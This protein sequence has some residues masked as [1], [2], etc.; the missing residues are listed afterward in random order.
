VMILN[1]L[2][3]CKKEEE[4]K[5]AEVVKLDSKQLVC[6]HQ[7]QCAAAHCTTIVTKRWG[8][9]LCKSCKRIARFEYKHRLMSCQKTIKKLEKRE[10][11]LD[12]LHANAK[13]DADKKNI[14]ELRSS[15]WKARYECRQ[16]MKTLL[17]YSGT[18]PYQEMQDEGW[19]M[20]QS[21]CARR[22]VGVKETRQLILAQN[23]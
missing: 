15:V 12:L 13:T 14:D 9:K 3:I 22:Y 23:K 21:I 7:K 17:I 8:E 2:G 11:R 16:D 19:R 6:R 4:L 18:K 1:P 20:V 5:S 10:H